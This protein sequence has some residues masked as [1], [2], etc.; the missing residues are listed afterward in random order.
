MSK[1]IMHVALCAT[2]SCAALG[3]AA[4]A[5]A[6]LGGMPTPAPASAVSSSVNMAVVHSAS[7]V[8]ATSSAA[9]YTVT[10][11]TFG[12]GTVVRE[13][14]SATG[15]VF[16]IAWSG[17]LM[18]N[19]P[20]LL[21]TYFTQYDSARVAQRAENPGRGPLNVEL[22]GLVVHSGGHMGSFSGQAYLPQSLPAG[23][24]ANDIQ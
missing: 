5:S 10:Q 22:P 7:G 4:P 16:G 6:E 18:P 13:Y 8:A 23:V 17:P 11:T 1:Q 9:S 3:A 14:A 20:V 19:L 15:T 24:S 12:T 2:L 21:G